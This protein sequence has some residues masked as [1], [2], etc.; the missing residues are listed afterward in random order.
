MKVALFLAVW[1]LALPAAAQ[2]DCDAGMEAIDA[3]ADF[4]VTA[5]EFTK[6][7]VQNERGLVKS[8]GNVGYA[9]DLKV[10]TLNGDSVDGEYHRT[11]VVEFD[12]GGTRRETIVG[13]ATN[14]IGRLKLADKDIAAL[15]DPAS[16][17][18]TAES[19][20]DRDI[21]YSGRQRSGERNLALF[22][23]VPRSQQNFGHAFAGRVWVRGR[24]TAIVKTCG[25]HADYPIAPMR[26]E[27]ARAEVVD[28]KYFPVTVRA[29]EEVPVD[30]VP[31]HVRVTVTYSDYKPRP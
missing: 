23:V 1:L 29:D 18:L 21:I 13:T 22:E 10:E 31:V 5:R 16:F 7:V 25:R 6:L 28:E 4:S 11:S 26:Y 20:G 14:S 8:L 9:V 17:A 15:A 27:I 30:G 3:A 2:V 19:F 12:A 24:G